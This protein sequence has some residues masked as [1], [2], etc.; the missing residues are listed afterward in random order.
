MARQK[1]A[2]AK[3]S[4]AQ[5]RADVMKAIE[6]GYTGD[7][8]VDL[9]FQD[10]VNLDRQKRELLTLTAANRSSL[11]NLAVGGHVNQEDVDAIY[12]PKKDAEEAEGVAAAS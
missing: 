2:D 7:G 9:L 4:P 6:D 5:I 12:P 10:A 8:I 1:K 3:P 11:R